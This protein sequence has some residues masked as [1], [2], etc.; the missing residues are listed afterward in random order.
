MTGDVYAVPKT[1][2]HRTLLRRYAALVG[3]DQ[4]L[5]DSYDEVIARTPSAKMLILTKDPDALIEVAKRD[6][7]A[8]MFH[9]I[10]GSPDPFFVE[11]LLP[12]VTKGSGLEIMC[13][14]LGIPVEQS[15]AF[16][17][18][19]NDVEFLAAAGVGCAMKNAR[20]AAKTAA[21]ITIEVSVWELSAICRCSLLDFH[22]NLP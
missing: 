15:V 17:D 12:G 5:I 10:R 7:P 14:K 9:I 11:F 22:L 16:G 6:L 2:E 19:E 21:N 8:D 18:G 20:P 13:G 4:V 1:E 3:K